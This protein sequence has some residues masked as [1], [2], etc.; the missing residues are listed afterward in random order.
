VLRRGQRL[1]AENE[2]LHAD[3]DPILIARSPEMRPVLD[4]VERVGPGPPR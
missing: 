1:E 4:R 2:I 3:G